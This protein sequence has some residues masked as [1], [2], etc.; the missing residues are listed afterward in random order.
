MSKN[1]RSRKLYNARY[2]ASRFLA[3]LVSAW[4]SLQLLN[5]T[6]APKVERT[7][8]NGTQG[9]QQHDAEV[10]HEAKDASCAKAEATKPGIPSFQIAGKTIDLTILA[11]ARALDTLIVNIWHRSNPSTT[12][13]QPTS[14]IS[15]AISHYTDTLVFALSSGTVMW[16]WVYHPNHLPRAYKKWIG[17]AAQVDSRLVELLREAR[18]GRMIYGQDTGLAPILQSMCKDYEWPLEWGDLAKTAPIPCEMVH[19]G[20]GPSCHWHA[21]LRFARG[22]KFAIATYLPL[23]L[24]I[25]G[26]K[27][28]VLAF[29]R[30]CEE[31]VRSSAFLGAFVGLFYYGICLSRTRLGPKLFSRETITPMMWDSGLC[32]MAGC[33]LCGWSILLEAEKRRQELAMFVAPRALATFLPREYDAKVSSLWFGFQGLC[34]NM[35]V[36]SLERKGSIFGQYSCA[37]HAG[38]RGPPESQRDSRPHITSGVEIVL[39]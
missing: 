13:S 3:A 23:Q 28:S 11:V 31:A 5:A 15:T 34:A 19:M 14:L 20:T 8:P 27:P 38:S 18:A 1:R 26:R 33:I 29:R 2:P 4:F 6:K 35:D 22:F 36:V 37:V 32:I 30:A 7:A 16:A 9:P 39:Y 25:K 10:S 17:Q 12:T 21:A 24:L